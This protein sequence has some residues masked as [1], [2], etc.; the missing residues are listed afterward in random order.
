MQLVN[1]NLPTAPEECFVDPNCGT[2][3][4]N[5]MESTNRKV[6]SFRSVLSYYEANIASSQDSASKSF[7]TNLAS[8]PHKQRRR[9]SMG[10]VPLTQ[11]SDTPSSGRI[12]SGEETPKR[13]CRRASWCADT[14]AA[15]FPHTQS[16]SDAEQSTAK[17][18]ITISQG[19][20]NETRAFFEGISS[21]KSEEKSRMGRRSSMGPGVE[22]LRRQDSFIKAERFQV[23]Q[24]FWSTLP[25]PCPEVVPL[26]YPSRWNS[27]ETIPETVRE[28][29][30]KA[31]APAC[32]CMDENLN[33][34]HESSCMSNAS[35]GT[36]SCCGLDQD[37]EVD[38]S[39]V[40]SSAVCLYDG[41]NLYLT[42]PQG[43]MIFRSNP[44]AGPASPDH[45]PQPPSRH[46]SIASRGPPSQ[47]SLC[48]FSSVTSIASI[49][50]APPPR[51]VRFSE[52]NEVW[53][54]EVD[55]L[56]SVFSE[57]GLELAQDFACIFDGGGDHGPR[58][59][60]RQGSIGSN[61][62]QDPGEVAWEY[63]GFYDE[64]RLPQS[65]GSAFKDSQSDSVPRPR[66]RR[67]SLEH[68][69]P[70]LF[71][72]VQGDRAPQ[73]A[74]RR[75]SMDLEC[76]F[77]HSEEE[78][79]LDF[80]HFVS[81]PSHV[82]RRDGIDRPTD[83]SQIASSPRPSSSP[84]GSALCSPDQAPRA[85]RRR[86]SIDT[87]SNEE[88]IVPELPSLPCLDK[89]TGPSHDVSPRKA[90][91]R[92]SIDT[93]QKQSIPKLG[94]VLR[95]TSSSTDL[96][97]RTV[98]TAGTCSPTQDVEE[99]LDE[100]PEVS[101][102]KLRPASRASMSDLV[103][104]DAFTVKTAMRDARTSTESDWTKGEH[105]V[106][107][108]SKM[109]RRASASDCLRPTTFRGLSFERESEDARLLAQVCTSIKIDPFFTRSTKT[110]DSHEGSESTVDDS[111]VT[112]STDSFRS[113]TD[114]F[115]RHDDPIFLRCA[116][117]KRANGLSRYSNHSHDK[118]H[119]RKNFVDDQG[120][121]CPGVIRGYSFSDDD[122]I[123]DDSASLASQG[124][125]SVV[126]A[127]ESLG[128]DSYSSAP[129]A[130]SIL[131]RESR[132]QLNSCMSSDTVSYSVFFD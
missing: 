44:G 11:K 7:L 10:A 31:S 46:G 119:S 79:D 22:V 45:V 93:N 30:L 99:H 82:K 120:I 19:K 14:D 48:S 89:I 1:A 132:Q 42:L 127:Q 37:F 23:L 34:N 69:K 66:R 105:G 27:M 112:K 70:S 25:K 3:K 72:D 96:D 41:S 124:N 100:S 59:V 4:A 26:R 90:T 75:G 106:C 131:R 50:T 57:N 81:I 53:L 97:L 13:V 38:D 15:S 55:D 87:E 102:S 123:F 52:E 122:S 2:R 68:R 94:E 76:V 35:L 73:V 74:P 8:S 129:K 107:K 64:V 43:C 130:M 61:A 86:G 101:E 115:P 83:Q 5:M 92:Q 28:I 116:P 88:T 110:L 20:V 12:R 29:A 63:V 21:P 114:T 77:D 128:P 58:Q 9:L 84:T 111:L 109:S 125:T 71:G 40:H 36:L 67:G 117:K 78:E 17:P 56:C 65:F 60:R 103:P 126:S 32:L 91:R 108:N 62:S 33:S 39:S 24:K 51:R 47:R 95:K 118:S 49:S 18:S 6:D 80:D 16:R 104:M 54:F 113:D 85:I 121:L 98:S